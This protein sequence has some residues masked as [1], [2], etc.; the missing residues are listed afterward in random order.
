MLKRCF[1]LCLT[2]LFVLPLGAQGG[3]KT[4]S[5][6]KENSKPLIRFAVSE[7]NFFLP[8]LLPHIMDIAGY[9][10]AVINQPFSRSAWSLVN[11]E[12]EVFGPYP[13]EHVDDY[14]FKTNIP[15]K[16][17]VRVPVA[18]D[19]AP[20]FGISLHHQNM[21]EVLYENQ[22]ARI[23]HLFSISFTKPH[24]E[25]KV[26]I[27]KNL[28]QLIKLLKINRIDL[29]LISK[30]QKDELHTLYPYLDL[31]GSK[32]PLYFQESFLYVH[33]TRPTLL[34]D[35]DKAFREIQKTDYFHKV[36]EHYS[37]EKEWQTD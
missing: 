2:F 14:L 32:R 13:Q 27:A 37:E 8:A 21:R 1:F 35:L 3:D 17:I 19:S 33:A 22:L 31:I 24:R 10:Y 6:S 12:I 25:Q 18:V 23:G 9:D 20:I 28:E 34:K 5:I 7:K 30:K 29:A 16:T 4:V 11:N 36:W 26:T 15:P